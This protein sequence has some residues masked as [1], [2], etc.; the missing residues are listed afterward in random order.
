[1]IISQD[2]HNTEFCH[3]DWSTSSWCLR[4]VGQ[5]PSSEDALESEGI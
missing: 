1:L 3:R 4:H 2:L 5:S